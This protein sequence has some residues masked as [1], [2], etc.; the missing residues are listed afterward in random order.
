MMGGQN[1]AVAAVP[2]S[3]VRRA[4]QC[5]CAVRR[6]GCNLLI[7]GSQLC[8]GQPPAAALRNQPPTNQALQS[9]KKNLLKWGGIAWAA[10]VAL[11]LYHVTQGSFKSETAVPSALLHGALAALC[12]WR[13]FA[14]D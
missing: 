11:G 13:G 3:K 12:L 10:S 7:C 1:F 14:K 9:A 6:P 8:A 4:R 2:A 5:I